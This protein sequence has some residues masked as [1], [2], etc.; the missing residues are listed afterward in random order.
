[1]KKLIGV[2]VYGGTEPQEYYV[3][4]RGVTKI[5]RIVEYSTSTV[6]LVEVIRAPTILSFEGSLGFK[7]IYERGN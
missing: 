3:G 4:E 1:M 2:E 5:A 6:K 7:S